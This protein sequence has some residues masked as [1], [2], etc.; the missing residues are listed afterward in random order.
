MTIDEWALYSG[1][2]RSRTYAAIASGHIRAVKMGRL[3]RVDTASGDA[4]LDTLPAAPIKAATA[5]PTAA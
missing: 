4:Y 5:E 2:S 3:V 1:M